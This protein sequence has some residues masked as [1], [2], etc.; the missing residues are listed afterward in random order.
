MTAKVF[1]MNRQMLDVHIDGGATGTYTGHK[2]YL[3]GSVRVHAFYVYLRDDHG[4]LLD[5]AGPFDDEL[6]A[7]LMAERAL[8]QAA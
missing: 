4:E 8:W 1:Y 6:D 2:G 5:I 3:A 7:E